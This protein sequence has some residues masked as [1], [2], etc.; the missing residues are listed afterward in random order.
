MNMPVLAFLALIAFII[1]DVV[2]VVVHHAS[3]FGQW[4]MLF[5]G[6]ALWVA[7]GLVAPALGFVRRTP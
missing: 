4:S 5:A 1:G 3:F 6:L 7:S 2:T